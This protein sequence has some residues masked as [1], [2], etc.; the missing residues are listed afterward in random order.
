MAQRI[1]NQNSYLLNKSLIA[2]D[3][4]TNSPD[5]GITKK[6][7]TE[8]KFFDS[9]IKTRQLPK[10]MKSPTVPV[11][12]QIRWYIWRKSSMGNDMIFRLLDFF[13]IFCLV[14]DGTKINMNENM[15][16]NIFA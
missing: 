5:K 13:W 10:L 1:M 11:L 4:S 16:Y 6:R 12:E 2:F 7:M 15:K 14:D 3:H 8:L 9:K